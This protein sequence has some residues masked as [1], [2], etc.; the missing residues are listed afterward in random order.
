MVIVSLTRLTKIIATHLGNSEKRST[1]AGR[2]GTELDLGSVF[3][4]RLCDCAGEIGV[5]GRLRSLPGHDGFDVFI[6][7]DRV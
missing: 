5:S 1:F 7:E 6:V 4:H 2:Y 3:H